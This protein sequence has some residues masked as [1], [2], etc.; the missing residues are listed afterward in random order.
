M[1]YAIETQG[2]DRSVGDVFYIDAKDKTK[3]RHQVDKEARKKALKPVG[4][5]STYEVALKEGKIGV[6]V[7]GQKISEVESHEYTEPGHI[8]FQ[9]EGAEIH[10]KNIRIKPL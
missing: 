7:N 6:S 1:A 2:R 5:W 4:E 9:S 10:W 3:N 8:G